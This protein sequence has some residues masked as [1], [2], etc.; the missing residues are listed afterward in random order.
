MCVTHWKENVWRVSTW[1]PLIGWEIV[2][3]VG[4]VCEDWRERRWPGTLCA[5]LRQDDDGDAGSDPRYL[6]VKSTSPP[7][8]TGCR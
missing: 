2:L 8:L 3:V 4:T 6:S 5:A 1:A 7:L